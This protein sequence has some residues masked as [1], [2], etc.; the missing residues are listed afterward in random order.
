MIFGP[1]GST[2]AL[3]YTTY[4]GGGQVRRISRDIR[5]EGPL[6]FF[7]VTPCRVV[8]TRGANGP[9][10]G[11]GTS[12]TFGLTGFCGLPPTARAV[13]AN[14]TAVPSSAGYLVFYRAD[15]PVGSNS[16][17]NFSAGVTRANN[18]VLP[19][20]TGG[21]VGV[22]CGVATGSVHLAIDVVGYFE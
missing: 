14:I 21:D 11:A 7:T 20:G 17:I 4:A 5:D 9:A 15:E 10:L 1:F 2:Q 18:A 3:Y 6:D 12:R 13:A 8:D 19:L 16:T 22:F